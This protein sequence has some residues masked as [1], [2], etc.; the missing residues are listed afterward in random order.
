MKAPL[1]YRLVQWFLDRFDANDIFANVRNRGWLPVPKEYANQFLPQKS[2]MSGWWP[3][4]PQG[5]P[6]PDS[7]PRQGYG[8]TRTPP[9]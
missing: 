2:V 6:T 7:Q 5:N 3:T 1:R 9:T 4:D 8:E